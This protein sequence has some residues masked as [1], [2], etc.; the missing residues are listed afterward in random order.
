MK[1]LLDARKL[2]DG[3]IGVYIENLVD[4]LLRLD[5]RGLIKAELTLLL[6]PSF[7]YRSGEGRAIAPGKTASSSK[8]LTSTHFRTNGVGCIVD[9]ARGRWEGRVRFVEESAGKYS[10]SELF[11]LG[12]RQRKELQAHDIYHSPHYT[13]PYG[14]PVPAVVT[15]HDLIHL[16]HPETR[17]HRPVATLLV[18]SA[19]RRAKHIISVSNDAAGR[20]REFAGLSSPP[21]SVVPNSLRP[22]I[23]RRNRDEVQEFRRKEFLSRPY[24][25]YIGSERPH[26]GFAELMAAWKVLTTSSDSPPDLVVVGKRFDTAR[27]QVQELGLDQVVRFQGE[28]SLDKLALLYSGASAVVVP[29]RAEGFGLPALEALGLGVPVVCAPIPVLREVCGDAAIFAEEATGESF[30]QAISLV[31]TDRELVERKVAAGLARVSKFSVEECALKTWSVYEQVLGLLPSV[32][33]DML[34]RSGGVLPNNGQLV[35]GQLASAVTGG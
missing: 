8:A 27:H 29:S 9:A 18:R 21:L 22:S 28:V 32:T 2:G 14:L 11:L 25:L 6:S 35:S 17:Y 23:S 34:N 20:I 26:K 4:G 12:L 19:L 30:A 1:I 3:G 5:A 13:L 31:M 15:I 24:C 10:F 7:F 16:S 33:A